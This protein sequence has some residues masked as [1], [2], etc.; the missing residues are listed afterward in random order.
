MAQSNALGKYTETGL[1][2]VVLIYFLYSSTA[3]ELGI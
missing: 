2:L 3:R 1:M